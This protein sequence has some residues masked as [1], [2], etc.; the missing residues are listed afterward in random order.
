MTTKIYEKGR[1]TFEDTGELCERYLYFNAF[2]SYANEHKLVRTEIEKSFTLPNQMKET[3]YN[4]S[5]LKI[6]ERLT[7]TDMSLEEYQSALQAHMFANNLETEY[8]AM[9]VGLDQ[10][11]N[12]PN[13]NWR[14]DWTLVSTTP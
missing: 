12:D 1:C 3:I 11:R 4:E 2:T 9:L 8:Q 10:M 7:L 14:L 5:D 13:I 6:G